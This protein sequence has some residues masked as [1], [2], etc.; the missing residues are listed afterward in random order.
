MWQM[1]RYLE[2]VGK[3][4]QGLCRGWCAWVE[5]GQVHAVWVIAL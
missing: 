2:P 1:G 5:C 3:Q 4:V